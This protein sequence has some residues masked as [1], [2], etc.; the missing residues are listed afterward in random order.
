MRKTLFTLLSLLSFLAIEA[1]QP[2]SLRECVDLALRK[3]PEINTL[4]LQ[5]QIAKIDYNAARYSQLPSLSAGINHGYNFG[6]SIDR[7]T[8]QFV[9]RRIQSD[10]FSM[11]ANWIVYG[12]M[13]V[14]NSIRQQQFNYLAGLK[15]Q[16]VGRNRITMNV[17][18]GYLSLL[19]SKAVAQSLQ[20][21]VEATEKQ[22]ARTE[23]LA[24]AGAVDRGVLLGLE[25]QLAQEQ[26][27]LIEAQNQVKLSKIALQNLLI[28]PPQ[29]W[30]ILPPSEAFLRGD[31]PYYL[32]EEVFE[33]AKKNMPELQSSALRVQSAEAMIAM[34]KGMR[35]PT[36]AVYANMSTVFSENALE[37]TNLIPTGFQT[38]GLTQNTNEP[39]VQPTFRTETRVIPL[40]NQLRNNFGQTVGISMSWNIFNGFSVQNN[41]EKSALNAS[42]Q[43]NAYVQT[44]NSLRAAVSKAIADYDASRARWNA[45]AV[46]FRAADLQFE[47]A[48]K[49]FE[50]G[51]SNI[52]DYTAAKNQK[53][54]AE[55]SFLQAQ[56]EQRFNQLVVAFYNGDPLQLE[57]K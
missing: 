39:V 15:D 54:R 36:I 29:D 25:S 16:E 4:Y 46:A 30:D 18:S 55:I 17:V 3:N 12:G 5:T 7:F 20:S 47:F 42:I 34:A 48:E 22:V 9:N 56:Y 10:Y 43:Q 37:L 24:K 41:I 33:N 13:Q 57:E 6:R 32:V 38:I 14:R 50:N 51:L 27:S 26:L 35:A 1:Q 45:S 31:L 21:Q 53:I 11:S 44:E 2:L 23:K 49:R 28:S 19:M 52:V 40:S 8:N